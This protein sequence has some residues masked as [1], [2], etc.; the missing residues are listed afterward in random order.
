[1]PATSYLLTTRTNET[2]QNW[3]HIGYVLYHKLFLQDNNGYDHCSKW[4]NQ[5]DNI[6]N[7]HQATHSRYFS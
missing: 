4:R 7:L 6:P 1:M 2:Y 5:L 3:L